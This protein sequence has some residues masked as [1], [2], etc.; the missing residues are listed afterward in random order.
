MWKDALRSRKA[1]ILIAVAAG[2]LAWQLWLTIAAPQK[3]A[4]F[5]G[6]SG[7]ESGCMEAATLRQIGSDFRSAPTRRRH[8][9]IDRAPEDRL[10]S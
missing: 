5:A 6:S 3:I 1:H 9:N 7:T 10:R 8:W 2:Y 4:N